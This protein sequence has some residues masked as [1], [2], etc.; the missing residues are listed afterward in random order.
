MSRIVYLAFPAGGKITGGQK[1]IL[2]HV[3]TLCEL[4]FDAVLWLNE[5]MTAPAWLDH[6]CP[7]EVATPFRPDDV[8]VLPEDAPNAI[9]HVA[10]QANRAVILCQSH[11]NLVA[12]GDEALRR[13]PRDRFPAFMGVGPRVVAAIRRDYPEADVELVHCFADERVFHP[14]QERRPAVV[15][16][17]RK[18]PG[19]AMVIR[20]LFQRR[21][22]RHAGLPWITL[23]NAPEQAVAEAMGS[24]TLFLALGRQEAVGLTPLEAMA[25]GCVVAGFRSI[26]GGDFAT[27]QNGFWAPEEDCEA[28]ADALA[29]AADLVA[30]GGPALEQTL[31]A[32]AATARE[33]SYEAFRPRLESFW[34]RIA[35]EARRS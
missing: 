34:S 19:E 6:R 1:M 16:I 25:S 29:Q 22:P 11:L 12:I 15:H 26:G 2:R 21:H 32:A 33:W 31:D 27:P 9:R 28:A 10:G 7:V 4:G 5:G 20:S 17:P 30:A 13:F 18:R 23:E 14:R 8:L 35:P 3:E 24:S